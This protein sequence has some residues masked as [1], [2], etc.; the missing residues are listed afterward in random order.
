VDPQRPDDPLLPDQTSD[1]E[2][3]VDT[4]SDDWYQSERPPHHG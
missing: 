1:E 4:H 3:L 2:D